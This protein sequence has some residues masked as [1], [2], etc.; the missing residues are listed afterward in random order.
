MKKPT[1]ILNKDHSI[2]YEES[3]WQLDMAQSNCLK[4][5]VCPV[6]TLL[7]LLVVTS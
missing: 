6:L 7:I 2:N 1:I 5:I 4:Y 3:H